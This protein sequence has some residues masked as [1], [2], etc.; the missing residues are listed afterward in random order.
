MQHLF[1]IIKNIT[2]RFKKQTQLTTMLRNTEVFRPTKMLH[3]KIAFAIFFY[4]IRINYLLNLTQSVFYD[5]FSKLDNFLYFKFY[6]YLDT[7]LLFN[8]YQNLYYIPITNF[9]SNLF[10]NVSNFFEIWLQTSN[11]FSL[12]FICSV[13]YL[14]TTS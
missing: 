10:S 6:I 1:K 11:D 4:N 7:N 12:D 9:K 3:I 14:N 2:R 8:N 13:D 5:F